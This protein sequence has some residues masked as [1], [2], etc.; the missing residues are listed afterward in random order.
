MRRKII[1]LVALVKI[2]LL[3]SISAHASFLGAIFGSSNSQDNSIDAVTEELSGKA[4]HLRPE[5]LKLALNAYVSAQQHGVNINK[6]ILTVIDYSMPSSEKRMW[7]M[8]VVKKQVLYTSLVAHGKGSGSNLTATQFS[9]NSGSLQSSLGVFLTEDTY[10]G[11]NGITLK[12]K[13]LEKGF[14]EKAEA[15]RIVIH[16]AWYATQQMAKMYG[17]IGKS[18]GCPAVEPELATP[19]INTIKDGSLVFAYYPDSN[20]LHHSRYLHAG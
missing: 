16:G 15:R 13:G 11:H 9:D 17:M 5:V 4:K 14:N 19:I 18:W 8:D 10:Q 1:T 2:I 6:P 12:I 7:V 20:W 3:F